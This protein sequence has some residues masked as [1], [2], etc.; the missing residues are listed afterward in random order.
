MANKQFF[1]FGLSLSLQF[2]L[3]R[4]HFFCSIEDN[5]DILHDLN[6]SQNWS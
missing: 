4:L 1:N 2:L 5:L 6:F 3:D